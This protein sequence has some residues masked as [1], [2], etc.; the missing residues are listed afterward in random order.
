MNFFPEETVFSLK[1]LSVK[2]ISR[3]R[4]IID[5]VSIELRPAEIVSLL[6]PSGSGKSTTALAMM[7][8]LRSPL[9]L[10]GGRAV[11]DGQT[12]HFNDARQLSEIRGNRLSMI[13]QDPFSSLNPVL[14]CG[15]QAEEPLKIH[16][17]AGR[18]ERREQILELFREVGF[19][20]PERIY[21]S[22][23]TELSGG[24]LQR[25]MLAMATI[26]EPSVLLADEPTTALDP[27]SQEEVIKLLQQ[28]RERHGM[29][30]LL[31][32]HDRE[33]ASSVSDRVLGMHNGRLVGVDEPAA[34]FTQVGSNGEHSAIDSDLLL[35]VSKMSKTFIRNGVFTDKSAQVKALDDINLEMY[36][37]EVVG[38]VGPS[39]SGKTTLGRCIAGL[40]APDCGE[41]MLNG[42]GVNA[43]RGRRKPSPVQMVYQ[44]PYAS[45]NP[46]MRIGESI[47]EGP[48]TRGMARE[49]RRELAIRL[50]EQVDLSP[51][52]YT[53]FPHA[54]S[55]GE[56]QRVV[57]ARA[58]AAD[59]KLLVADEP[60]ASLDEHT[61][62][63]V[64]DLLKRLARGLGFAVLLI[65]HDR[66]A[67]LRIS[68]RVMILEDGKLKASAIRCEGEKLI[69]NKEASVTENMKSVMREPQ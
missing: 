18:V 62:A 57:I 20:E 64:L 32:T 11:L 67:I 42:R 15:K 25:V 27:E 34:G 36:R 9:E 59:P 16:T 6:G 49:Q 60:T 53:R 24:Q 22:L 40:T 63:Q 21:S 19:G 48:R 50:L 33:L 61:G 30:I 2:D 47:E 65:S 56:R 8:L 1:D 23:P 69:Q 68:D 14:P 3:G 41:I 7:G 44:S 43:V 12:V 28:M 35:T 46:T 55:G 54:L 4:T 66:K 45:L 29:A 58:L 31:I 26:L 38:I 51:T 17:T 13:F 5:S 10:V 52:F 39:G 37:G